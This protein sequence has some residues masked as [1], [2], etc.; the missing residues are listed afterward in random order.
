MTAAYLT[1]PEKPRAIVPCAGCHACC[2][3][4]RVILYPEYGDDVAS[5]QT[6]PAPSDKIGSMIYGA[7]PRRMLCHKP[8]MDC[9]YLGEDGCTIWDRAPA[10]CRQFDCRK[11]FM[12]FTRAERRQFRNVLD[13][14][15]MRAGR[16]RLHTLPRAP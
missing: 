6:E 15:V 7:E 4:E 13:N 3:R 10:M 2:K 12:R 8:N 11:M 1:E 9:I 5:Y 14:D 16:E